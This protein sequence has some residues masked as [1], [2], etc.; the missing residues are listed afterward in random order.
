MKDEESILTSKDRESNKLTSKIL[1]LCYICN[2]FPEDALLVFER[3][4]TRFSNISISASN[5]SNKQITI[6]NIKDIA[7]Q[8]NSSIVVLSDMT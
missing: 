1:Q 2:K 5:T 4:K 8:I 7:F 6:E 3:S